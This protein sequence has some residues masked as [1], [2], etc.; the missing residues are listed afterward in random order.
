[1]RIFIGIIL[2]LLMG[3][4]A[5]AQSITVCFVWT[6]GDSDVP[7]PQASFVLKH[8]PTGKQQQL[9]TQENGEVVVSNLRPGSYQL[10]LPISENFSTLNLPADGPQSYR[11]VV[12]YYDEAWQTQAHP[13]FPVPLHMVDAQNQPLAL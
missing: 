4:G 10:Q 13:T 5:T 11:I 7:M 12:P 8:I 3:M 9:Q 6:K 1:M 2:G